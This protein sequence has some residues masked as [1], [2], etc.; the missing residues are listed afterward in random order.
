MPLITPKTVRA[1]IKENNCG[2]NLIVPTVNK[3]LYPLFGFYH[4]D[5]LVHFENAFSVKN[6]ILKDI[7]KS[8]TS[9]VID[10]S[11][12]YEELTNV[13]TKEHLNIVKKNL[14]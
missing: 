6:Y 11:H 4:Q 2:N 7:L 13:N 12:Y 8:V 3:K 5:C 14:R 1:L 10:L 9:S